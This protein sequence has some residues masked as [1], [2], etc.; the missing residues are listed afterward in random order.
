[1][2]H[3]PIFFAS[4]AFALLMTSTSTY[5]MPGQFSKAT[6]PQQSR[7]AIVLAQAE[8]AEGEDCAQQPQQK[9]KAPAEAAP[10]AEAQPP[11]E[12]APAP[13]PEA[14]PAPEPEAAPA[15]APEPEPAPEP[16]PQAEPQPAPE[17]APAPEQKAQPQEP[18]PEPEAAP[19]PEA[20]QPAAE[21]DQQPKAPPKRKQR[22]QVEQVPAPADQAEP[23]PQAPAEEPAA[24]PAPQA[25][26]EE[27]APAPDAQQPNPAVEPQPA[28]EPQPEQPA[29]QPRAEQPAQAPN[30]GAEAP[31]LDSQKSGDEHARPRKQQRQDNAEAPP[32]AAP[33]GPPPA[34]DRAAQEALQPQ[35]IVPLTRERGKRRAAAPDVLRQERPQGADV[36]RQ[37]GDRIILNFGGQNV[38]E[39][40]DR[41]RLGRG[42]RDV[43]YEDL[44]GGRTRE[45][46]ER[47]NGVQV[48]TIRNRYGDVIKRS[49][50]TPDGR[51]Y[52]LV[53]AQDENL[54]PDREWRDPGDDLP[55]MELGIPAD[56]Y[57]FDAERARAP[58]DYYDFLSEP[59]VERVERLYSVDEVKRSARIRDKTRRIDLDT[60]TFDF[61]KASIPESEITRLEG[62]ATAMERLLKANPAE[63]FLI[64]GHT[65]AVGTDVANLALSDRRAESVADALS[66]VFGI[67]PENLATQGYGERYLKVRTQEPER[68]NRRVAIR[69]ITP[70]VAP[71]ASAN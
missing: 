15:P 61:G 22:K 45:I 65:D 64:E 62:V 8:C 1:M 68:E 47:E 44:P 48:V 4:G 57:I 5:A 21:P 51:E 43:Y 38:V 17:P 36:V 18:A 28:P 67:P 49:R 32:P 30:D 25:P 42:A 66:N 13:E 31:L 6:M 11:A 60:I 2:K 3:T 24:E 59:P 26:A 9:R 56:E 27:P 52:V 37:M 10:D 46:I 34:N 14:A 16:A 20:Q 41:Q 50:I 54:S 70:L 71:V 63:T 33:S 58:E 19:K 69:R 7:A 40:D 55:P 12:P 39:S 23:A 35:E 29:P 53:Y